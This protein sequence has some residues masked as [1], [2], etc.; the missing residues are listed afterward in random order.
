MNCSICNKESKEIRTLTDGMAVCQDCLKY[1]A[2]LRVCEGCDNE[3]HVTSLYKSEDGDCS[4]EFCIRETISKHLDYKSW[5][6]WLECCKEDDAPENATVEAW[7]EWH[8]DAY[9][10]FE[11]CDPHK[12]VMRKMLSEELAE[13]A[14]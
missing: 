12:V 4:C 11:D 13:K 9:S 8:E 6:D 10:A 5:S 7:L 14:S 1:S 3:F 2:M